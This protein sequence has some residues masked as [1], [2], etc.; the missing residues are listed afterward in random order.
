MPDAFPLNPELRPETSIAPDTFKQHSSLFIVHCSL[1]IHLLPFPEFTSSN[2][3]DYV[4]RTVAESLQIVRE[5]TGLSL[6]EISL[7]NTESSDNK[8]TYLGRSFWAAFVRG[9]YQGAVYYID[10]LRG[11]N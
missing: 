2:L 5:F 4:G 8:S 10:R 3:R 7:K 9:G 11:K 1:F 6:P